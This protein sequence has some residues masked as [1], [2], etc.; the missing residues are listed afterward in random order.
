MEI[1]FLMNLKF[2]CIFIF[3]AMDIFFL[4]STNIEN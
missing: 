2:P 1:V 4:I 3:I